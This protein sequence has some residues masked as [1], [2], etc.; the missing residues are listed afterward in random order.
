[1]KDSLKQNELSICYSFDCQVYE[2]FHVW[3]NLYLLKQYLTTQTRKHEYTALNVINQ[4]Y[5]VI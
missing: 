2:F 4:I 5:P 3:E 1:M